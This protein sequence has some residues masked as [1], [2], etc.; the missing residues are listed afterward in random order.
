MTH[1]TQM[2]DTTPSEIGFDEATLARCIDACFDCEQVCTACADACL[3]EE[4]VGM[5]RRCITLDLD[6]A[7]ICGATGRTLS[8]QTSFVGDL[9]RAALRVCLDACRLCAEECDRH[10]SMHE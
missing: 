3:G 9:S 4:D 6:C 1:A 10:A 7:D 2:L 8:R 5:L